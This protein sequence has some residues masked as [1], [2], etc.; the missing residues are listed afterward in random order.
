MLSDLEYIRESLELN[1]FFMRIAKE[2]SIFIEAAFTAKNTELAEEAETFKIVFGNLLKK[3]IELSD[4]ILSEDVIDSGELVTDLTLQAEK[5]TEFYTGIS[6]NSRL[7]K[8]E[9]LFTN[10][11]EPGIN[12]TF[13]Q[14]V[15][16]LN[17]QALASTRALA[18]YKARLLR[19]VL[20]CRLFTN[21]YP[22]LLDHILREAKFYAK[23]LMRLQRRNSSNTINDAIEEEIFW[24]RIMAEHSKFIRGLLDPTEVK[25]FD[26]ANDFGH[27]FDMLTVEAEKLEDNLDLFAKVTTES[28]NATEDIRG[29][30]R[31]GTQGLI[32][33]T[34][35]SIAYPL[36]GD[37]VVRE[38]NH[39]SRILK[40]YASM[41]ESK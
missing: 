34:I 30:K 17:Q 40:K 14:S 37:H 33:C 26:T 20:S 9:F 29:F 2:H 7:T 15:Y 31:Q 10:E 13:L 28:L 41:P 36:L 25:L 6:I 1:L 21:N 3:A 24:N 8:A 5:E 18:N 27:R 11:K 35:R 32:N 19:D 4:G 12:P 16:M 38:A 22:L 39:Y 23:N